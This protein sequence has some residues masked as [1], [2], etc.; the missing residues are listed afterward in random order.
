MQWS[1]YTQKHPTLDRP[2]TNNFNMNSDSWKKL[3]NIVQLVV[4]TR[5]ELARE[6]DFNPD[7]FNAITAAHFT[8]QPLTQDSANRV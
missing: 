4:T 6:H 2:T 3:A 8:G 5:V 1:N 7:L